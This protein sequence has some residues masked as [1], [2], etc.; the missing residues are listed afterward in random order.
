MDMPGE[1]TF[2]NLSGHQAFREV[3]SAGSQ[4][5]LRFFPALKNLHRGTFGGVTRHF[6][7][8]SLVHECTELA[9]QSF[10][11]ALRYCCLLYTSR[12]V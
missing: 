2:D 12:C 7:I 5:P 6:Q 10:D 8:I 1:P 11:R 9:L 4:I 3:R